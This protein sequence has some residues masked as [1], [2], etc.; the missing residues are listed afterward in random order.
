MHDE[1]TADLVAAGELGER[2][3][4][5]QVGALVTRDLIEEHRRNPVGFH[6]PDLERILRHLRRQPT[7]GKYVLVCTRRDEEWAIGELSGVR[8]VGP[9]IVGEERFSSLA[10]AQHGVFLRRL[11][12]LGAMPGEGPAR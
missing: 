6:S 7:A 2:M 9:R 10:A 3:L 8:G 12:A 5:E 11:E 4:T 1:P